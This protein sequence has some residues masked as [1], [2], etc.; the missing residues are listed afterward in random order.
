M[1]TIFALS[2]WGKNKTPKLKIIQKHKCTLNGNMGQ[3]FWELLIYYI[4]NIILNYGCKCN[5]NHATF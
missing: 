3:G 1:S 5:K 2:L 4:H